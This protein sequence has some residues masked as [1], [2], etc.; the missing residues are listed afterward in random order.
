MM[1]I[2]VKEGVYVDSEGY[3]LDEENNRVKKYNPF[4]LDVRDYNMVQTYY[5]FY[6]LRGKLKQDIKP[7]GE[8]HGHPLPYIQEDIEEDRENN[9]VTSH[10]RY[11]VGKKLLAYNTITVPEL[12]FQFLKEG[13][14][15]AES[16]FKVKQLVRFLLDGGWK[17]YKV[18]TR[19][20]AVSK[21]KT[22]RTPVKKVKKVVSKKKVIK[23]RK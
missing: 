20:K 14:E 12:T 19:K 17:Y 11:Y 13:Y 3:L 23:K 21:T 9:T 5:W 15:D 7:P 8:Y 1:R 4:K 22:K 6:D 2:K 18:E 16:R 10:L